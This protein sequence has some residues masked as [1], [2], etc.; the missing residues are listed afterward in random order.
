MGMP[1]LKLAFEESTVE[2]RLARLEANVEHIQSDVSEIKGD[3]RRLD[4]KIDRLDDKV[5]GVE[6]RLSVKIEDVR[7]LV[8]ALGVNIEK[9]F[10]KQTRW[11]FALY[12]GLAVGLFTALAHS[13]HWI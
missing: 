3:I 2:E 6:Q 12:I 9:A 4:D 13:L 11:A 8:A 7:V 1:A 10:L 5:D